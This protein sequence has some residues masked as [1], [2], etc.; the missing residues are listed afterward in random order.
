MWE[1]RN[2]VA[3]GFTN[4]YQVHR[5]VYVERHETIAGAAAREHQMKRWKRDWKL[6]LIEQDN[7]EW[8]DLYEDLNK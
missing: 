8:R 2:D 1:H 7:P 5:L 6:R 4:K 3:V